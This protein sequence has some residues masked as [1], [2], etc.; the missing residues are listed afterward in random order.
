MSRPRDALAD[1]ID[2]FARLPG[3]GRKTAGRLAFH[4]IDAP[5]DEVNFMI[6]AL[7]N[8]KT[9]IGH[10]PIC[11]NLSDGSPCKICLQS[12]RK[13][14]QLCVVEEVRD[15]VALERTQAFRGRYH[16]LGGHLSPM[17]GIGPNQLHIQELFRRLEEEDISEVILATN[18][19]VE[20]EATTLYLIEQ[21]KK[22]PVRTTRIAQGL[23][24]GADIKY[25]DDVTLARALESRFE[26]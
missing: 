17:D 19:S 13:N 5:D 22:Y 6:R 2:A 8:A 16:V 20:S 10:C 23:P 12:V 1:L 24:M 9:Q 21:L 14:G 3:I 15:I 7:E 25:A 4:I 26:V 18:S 11:G